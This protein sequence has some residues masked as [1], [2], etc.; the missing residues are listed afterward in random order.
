MP[1]G[2]SLLRRSAQW[3]ILVNSMPRAKTSL[4]RWPPSITK[5]E[6]EHGIQHMPKGAIK[7]DVTKHAPHNSYSPPLWYVN[8]DKKCVD[9]G[10]EFTFTAKQQQHWLEVLKL[11]IF[12][13]AN[14]CAAC[15]RK[16][17]KA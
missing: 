13:V 7:A 1:C 12:V 2:P 5:A 6:Y 15:R 11:P 9:C 10:T 14:R 17:R 3:L 16:Q 8:Q 4:R